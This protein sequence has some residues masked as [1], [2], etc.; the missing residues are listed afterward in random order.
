M[1]RLLQGEDPVET[2]KRH[3]WIN[4][5]W[6][7]DV[8]EVVEYMGPERVIFGSDWP[9]IE[10]MPKPLD[11]VDELAAFDAPTR[12]RILRDNA[13][14]ALPRR[15]RAGLSD[16]DA[17]IQPK[18]TTAT[19]AAPLAAHSTRT[20]RL[21]SPRR[22]GAQIALEHVQAD[23]DKERR[24]GQ[25]E[26]VPHG[27]GGDENRRTQGHCDGE[28]HDQDRPERLVLQVDP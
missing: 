14:R 4:P 17:Q 24:R 22:R 2:F 21:A 1:P 5:F 10:G 28:R 25:G 3:V 27:K 8:V 6:E 11:Y 18:A 23:E 13:P 7:D 9:H 20:L 15:C 12:Q 19:A 26:G 16:A